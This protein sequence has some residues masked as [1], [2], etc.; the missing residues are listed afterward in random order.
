MKPEAYVLEKW[1]WTEADFERMGWHDVRIHA[2]APIGSY[3]EPGAFLGAELW[4]DIDYILKWVSIYEP[5]KQRLA[6]K[7]QHFEFWLAPATL[8][9]EKVAGLTMKTTNELSQEWEIQDIKREKRAYPSG[10]ETWLWSIQL[11]EGLISF[12]ATGFNQYIRREPILHRMQFFRLNERSGI[13]FETP[14]RSVT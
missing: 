10:H 1:V 9:F 4:L 5:K 12:Q 8:I 14:G 3:F 11:Q 7:K 2:I 6:R 13:S